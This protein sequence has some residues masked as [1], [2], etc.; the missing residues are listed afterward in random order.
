MKKIIILF[1]LTGLLYGN[2]CMSQSKYPLIEDVKIEILKYG[3]I[4]NNAF[5]DDTMICSEKI[6]GV[7]EKRYKV[8]FAAKFFDFSERK[9]FDFNDISLVDVDR[10]IRYR[11]KEGGI[12]KSFWSASWY[13][14]KIKLKEFK[15]QD[16]FINNSLDGIK[17]FDFYVYH[18]FGGRINKKKPKYRYRLETA[19]FRR[20]KGLKL[21]FIFPALKEKKS[22]T[23]FEIYW[24]KKLVGQFKM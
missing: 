7:D 19:N 11:P 8:F 12:Y 14:S 16:N 5:G 13:S 10:K 1:A 24:K 22:P 6:N 23:N 9:S 18:S 2:N 3:L 15:S 17:N 20:K 4:D 21:I